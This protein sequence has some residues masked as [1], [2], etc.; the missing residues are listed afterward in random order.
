MPTT[1][2]DQAI[3]NNFDPGT[4]SGFPTTVT[5]IGLTLFDSDDDGLISANGSDQVNGSNVT[6][7]WN[8]DTVTLNGVTI[9]GTTFYTAD[10]GRYFTP[11]GSAVMQPGDVPAVTWV[12]QSTSYDV[13]DLGPPCF[14]SGTM[15]LTPTGERKIETLTLGDLVETR[16]RGAQPIRWIG[17]R[18]VSGQGAFAPVRFMKGALGNRRDL[19][20]SPQHRVII[21][22]WRAQLFLGEDEIFCPATNLCNGDSIHRDPCKEVTYFHLMFESHEVIYAE[23]AACES[24]LV[25]D[26]R[27]GESS[28]TRAEIIELFPELERTPAL[29]TT[30]RRVARKFET[31]VVIAR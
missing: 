6:N 8:G 4:A 14:V 20:V 16:D 27:A 10:G 23:G 13:D 17:S 5:I 18:S 12:N 3:G 25:G 28:A 29:F 1:Y 11:N 2:N 7:V 19:R 15:I 24:F 22:D 9:T 21:E 26:M 31:D 30:A